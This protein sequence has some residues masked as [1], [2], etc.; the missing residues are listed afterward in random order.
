ME[1]NWQSEG[2][3]DLFNGLEYNKLSHIQCRVLKALKVCRVSNGVREPVMKG[4]I[5][6]CSTNKYIRFVA[7][8]GSPAVNSVCG[9]SAIYSYVLGK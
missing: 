5:L 2:I 7:D 8:T 6:G 3:S 1:Y 4:R 9:V